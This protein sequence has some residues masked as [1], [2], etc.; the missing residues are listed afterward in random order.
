[1]GE[2]GLIQDGPGLELYSTHAQVWAI[3][4]DLVD[5]AQ[6]K[7]MLDKT[8]AV[9]GIPQCSV[10][11]SFYLMLA[12]DKVGDR[13]KMDKMWQPWRDMLDNNLTTCVEN[14]TDVRSDCHAWG[15]LML[16]AWPKIYAPGD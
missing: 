1:M 2:N 6:G 14:T 13:E 16:Y 7:E 12:L 5:T 3:L 8:F 10:S 4:N 11:M 9:A 15:A